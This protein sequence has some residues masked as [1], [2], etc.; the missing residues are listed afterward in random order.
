MTELRRCVEEYGFKAL[1][2]LP[3]LWGLP[4]DDRRYYP[5]FAAC[6]DEGNSSREMRAS[7]LS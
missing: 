5:L 6:C 2:I 1:R 3:W 4:P 7:L